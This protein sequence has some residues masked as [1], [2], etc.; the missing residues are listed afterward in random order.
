MVESNQIGTPDEIQILDTGGVN[1]PSIGWV[2]AA[3]TNWSEHI[4]TGVQHDVLYDEFLTEYTWSYTSQIQDSDGVDTVF[5]QYRHNTNGDWMNDTPSMISG[6]STDGTY[7][8]TFV[9]EIWWN[10][11]TSSPVIEEG[12]YTEFRI[13]ANDSLGNWRTTMPTFQNVILMVFRP[14]W[15][16]QLLQASPLI[17]VLGIIGALYIK[18]VIRRRNRGAVN[19]RN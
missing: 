19:Y 2:Y 11:T 6:D 9:Q 12:S 1:P 10:W 4:T 3:D 7:S 13:F 5:F 16:Y 17:F 14:P 15:Q 8:Y 18:V